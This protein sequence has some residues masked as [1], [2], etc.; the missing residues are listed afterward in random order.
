MSQIKFEDKDKLLGIFK[1]YGVTKAAI[2]GSQA[3]GE[4]K[5]TS[6]IDFL[7]E[8]EDSRSLMDLSGLKI[9][10]EELLNKNVDLVEYRLIHP[11]LKNEI[12]SEQAVIL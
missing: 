10:L 5:S 2:F 1:R 4:A 12:L 6:D 9:D 11:K 8:M 3:R 7:I